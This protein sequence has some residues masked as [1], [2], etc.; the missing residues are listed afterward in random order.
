MLPSP[1]LLSAEG[2]AAIHNDEEDF[3]S[4]V[5]E[6]ASFVKQGKVRTCRP[7][8]R[9]KKKGRGEALEGSRVVYIRFA[10]PQNLGQGFCDTHFP[11][12]QFLSHHFCLFFS[13]ITSTSMYGTLCTPKGV[14]TY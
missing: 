11:L 2:R 12:F 5:M 7:K 9:K 8:K 4:H 3:L 14:E 10:A 13:P 6:V 1:N